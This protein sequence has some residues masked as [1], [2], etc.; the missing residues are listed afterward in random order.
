MSAH[1]NNPITLFSSN[2]NLIENIH[3]YKYDHTNKTIISRTNSAVGE[4]SLSMA[5]FVIC[6]TE[7]WSNYLSDNQFDTL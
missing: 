4:I 5:Y 2:K 6:H 7:L 3:V 1:V